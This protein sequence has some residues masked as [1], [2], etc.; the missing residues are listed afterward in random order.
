MYVRTKF[1]QNPL[2]GS[3]VIRAQPDIMIFIAGVYILL[4]VLS[5]YKIKLSLA[6]IDKC[7]YLVFSSIT[8]R[9]VSASTCGHLQVIFVT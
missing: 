3:T 7:V 9:H 4:H 2:I 1:Y 6:T 5:N 8:S